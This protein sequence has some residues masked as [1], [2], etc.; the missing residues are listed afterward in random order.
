MFL[1]ASGVSS[2]SRLAFLGPD[3][4]QSYAL[5]NPLPAKPLVLSTEETDRMMRFK[6]IGLAAAAAFLSRALHSHSKPGMNASPNR[7]SAVYGFTSA[8]DKVNKGEKYR[9]RALQHEENS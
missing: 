7:K 6:D 1:I 4:R 9:K 2:E 3:H 8:R 5:M